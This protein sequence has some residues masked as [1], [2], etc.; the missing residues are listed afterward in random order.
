MIKGLE[1]ILSLFLLISSITSLCN[2]KNCKTCFDG[3]SLLNLFFFDYF[4]AINAQFAILNII[5]LMM[6]RNVIL[7]HQ[8]A[9]DAMIHSIVNIA[10]MDIIYP[11]MINAILVRQ[12]AKVA[13]INSIAILATLDTI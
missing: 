5:D 9:K 6:M 7:V 11:M 4:L 8:D 2:V 13:W 12:D 3:Y 10:I 1:I